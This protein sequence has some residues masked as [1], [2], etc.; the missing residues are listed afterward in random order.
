MSTVQDTLSTET[1]VDA[2]A[3]GGNPLTSLTIKERLH[4]LQLLPAFGDYKYLCSI[5]GI[6]DKVKFKKEDEQ[7]YGITEVPGGIKV[8]PSFDTV[9]FDISFT[10]DEAEIIRKNLEI[11]NNNKQLGIGQMEMFS[12]FGCQE[13][14]EGAIGNAINEIIK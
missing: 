14:D 12:K 3:S 5:R 7:T 10:N 11:L 2:K 13:K 8:D 4:V 9:V 1:K 6:V